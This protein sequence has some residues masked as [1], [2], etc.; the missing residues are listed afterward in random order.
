MESCQW[1]CGQLG[2]TEGQMSR[3]HPSHTS[4]P[5]QGPLQILMAALS[6][7][8]LTTAL[9]S[10]MTPFFFFAFSN[11]SHL[12]LKRWSCFCFTLKLGTTTTTHT[13]WF[14]KC[15]HMPYPT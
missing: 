14:S 15:F 8:L 10:L 1:G 9:S 12:I 2:L 11:T 7:G 6:S 3:Y 4:S 5:P 13:T